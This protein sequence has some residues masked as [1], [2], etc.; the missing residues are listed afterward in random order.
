MIRFFPK[1]RHDTSWWNWKPCSIGSFEG[2]GWSRLMLKHYKGIFNGGGGY[3]MQKVLKLLNMN[4][5][6]HNSRLAHYGGQD[7]WWGPRLSFLL[8]VV[9]VET[10]QD[11][12]IFR[13]CRLNFMLTEMEHVRVNIVHENYRRNTTR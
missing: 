13:N 2:V 8:E 10:G 12:V 4:T 11:G 6:L 9:Y 3:M 5:V 1:K 7:Y